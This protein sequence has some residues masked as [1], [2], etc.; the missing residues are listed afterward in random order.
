M[1]DFASIKLFG[2]LNQFLTGLGISGG[3]FAPRNVYSPK[4]ICW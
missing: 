1:R 3:A 2:L 4:Q